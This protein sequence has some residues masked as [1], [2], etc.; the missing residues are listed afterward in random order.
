MAELA[1]TERLH[2]AGHPLLGDLVQ[3]HRR[4]DRPAWWEVF[5]LRTLDREALVSDPTAIGGLSEPTYLRPEK[6]SALYEYSFPPQ[7]TKLKVGE[8]ALDVD[9]AKKAGTVF[10]LD[11]AAGRLVLKATGEPWPRGLG[12]GGPLNTTAQRT[13]IQA[14]GDDVLAGRDCLG[15]ALVER[16]V[17]AGTPLREGETRPTPSSASASRSTARCWPS[18]GRPAAARRPPRR[19]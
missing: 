5:R 6:K 2:E 10:E 13:A 9:T 4:E 15:Q 1:L 14:T 12:P 17:P 7:D 18:R 19:R 8:D 11:A 16:R 3:W